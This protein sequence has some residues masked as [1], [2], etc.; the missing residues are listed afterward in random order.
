MANTLGVSN[1]TRRRL[2]AGAGAVFIGAPFVARAQE[3]SWRICQSIALS[4]P[5]ATLGKEMLA[6]ASVCFAAVN[7]KGGVHGRKIDHKVVDDAYETPRALKNVQT[8]LADPNTFALFTCMGTPMI[9][10]ML[11]MV[12]ESMVPFFAPFSGALSI[13]PKEARNVFPIR[14][15]Y[16]EEAEK[17]IA[18]LQTIGVKRIG[19]AYQNNSFG[20]EIYDGAALAIERFKLPKAA[21]ATVESSGEDA[22][23]A[24]T[25][26]IGSNP[27]V[28]I[29]AMAGK[30]T[31]SFVKSMRAQ[32]RGVALYGLSVLG[33]AATLKELGDDGVGITLSQVVPSPS[34][35]VTPV[36]RD[37]QA[38]WRAAGM[39]TQ[40]S[41]LGLEGYINARIFIEA[42]RRAGRNATRESFI[43]TVWGIKGLDLGG[44]EVSFTEP[45]KSASRFV[46]LT[47]VG[48]GG[49]FFR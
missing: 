29:V 43:K 21:M 31:S 27:E 1:S 42:L 41:Y 12:T 23:A 26:L 48:P 25:K 35:T 3:N 36:V 49:R 24:A 33:S 39:D 15:S 38:A 13:R 32:R 5:P 28:V 10:A 16:S 47:M 37:F 45:G 6:G 4:G 14:I 19:I 18:H 44:F 20:K 17:L 7:A 22:A 11:P 34:S 8:F 9:E 30:P 40:P 46:E 2:I